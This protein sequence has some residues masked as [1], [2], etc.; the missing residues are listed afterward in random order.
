VGSCLVCNHPNR[1]QIDA[2]LA[3]RLS[4]RGMS[5]TYGI[6]HEAIA[7][8]RDNHLSQTIA[9][10]Q[11]FQ[12]LATA[13][14]IGNHIESLLTNCIKLYAACNEWLTD[15][16]DPT[17]Y[18]INPRAEDVDVIYYD[19]TPGEEEDDPPIV[20]KTRSTA[21]L[22]ALLVKTGGL[23]QIVRWKIADPRELLLKTAQTLNQQ[24]ELIA[25]VRKVINEKP[26]V[27][28][29]VNNIEIQA[30]FVRVSDMLRGMAQRHPELAQELQQGM[31]ALEAAG[32]N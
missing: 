7:R 18:N 14:G 6:T 8:H 5:R 9:Q 26:I 11:I 15:P 16:A 28:Q 4:I 30:V 31:E 29:T 1:D 32:V 17:K 22:S 25:R 20:S 19:V 13:N 12:D 2:G 10:A 24:L 23:A 3:K 27:Q 21:K